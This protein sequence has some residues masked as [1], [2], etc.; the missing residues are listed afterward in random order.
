MVNNPEWAT[1]KLHHSVSQIVF[2][3]FIFL[4]T[5]THLFDEVGILNERKYAIQGPLLIRFKKFRI[6]LSTGGGSQSA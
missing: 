4:A 1:V 5:L 2:N 3:R 6:Q